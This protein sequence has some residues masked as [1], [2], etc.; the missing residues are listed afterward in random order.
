MHSIVNAWSP[1]YLLCSAVWRW[2]S[3]SSDSMD[4]SR[5][6]SRSELKKSDCGWRSDRIF[7]KYCGW[8]RGAL[9][10]VAAGIAFGSA[11]AVG[12]AYLLGHQLYGVAPA[13][14]LTLLGSTALM[15]AITLLAVSIPAWKASRIDP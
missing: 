10:L 3:P 2:R 7:D 12:G 8:V 14:P 11:V 15:I 9:L 4:Y 1:I 5:I 13:D 6:P